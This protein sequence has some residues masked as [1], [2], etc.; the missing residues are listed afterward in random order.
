MHNIYD[1]IEAFTKLFNTEYHLIIGRKGVNVSIRITF[2]KKNCFHLMGLQHLTD[3]PKLNRDRGKIF[4][5]IKEHK[6][7]LENIESSDF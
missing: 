7:P 5:E 2:D 6:I 4:D 3:R 1:F